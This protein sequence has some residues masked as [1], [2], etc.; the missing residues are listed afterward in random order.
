MATTMK[1]LEAS[2]SKVAFL[3]FPEQKHSDGL[4]CGFHPSIKTHKLMAD[5]LTAFAKEKLGW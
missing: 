2:M 4:G 1:K 3:E 5:R